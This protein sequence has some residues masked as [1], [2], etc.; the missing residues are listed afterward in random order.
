M[1]L[2]VLNGSVRNE[3]NHAREMRVLRI[4]F[5]IEFG[6][7]I[8]FVPEVHIYSPEE[9]SSDRYTEHAKTSNAERSISS[10]INFVCILPFEIAF[11]ALKHTFFFN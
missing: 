11:F 8:D 6:R 4:S 2:P 5:Y 3:H 10:I 1:C 9:S 7:T